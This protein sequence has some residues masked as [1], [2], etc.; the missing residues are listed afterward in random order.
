MKKKRN[1]IG[2]LLLIIVLLVV[3]INSIISYFVDSSLLA[4]HRFTNL[5]F[6]VMMPALIYAIFQTGLSEELFFR[7]FLT[8]R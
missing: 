8:K 3:P 1:Y 5:G 6:S 2:L 4:S 7:G